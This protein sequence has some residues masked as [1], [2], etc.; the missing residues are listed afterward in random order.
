[1]QW[2]RILLSKFGLE[3]KNV[4]LEQEFNRFGLVPLIGIVSGFEE[5]HDDR[6][7]AVAGQAAHVRP[8]RHLRRVRPG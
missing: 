2:T 5:P 6:L 1:M 3:K 4:H 7:H 8:R